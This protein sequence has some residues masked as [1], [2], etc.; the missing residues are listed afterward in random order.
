MPATLRLHC[1]KNG[2]DR[3]HHGQLELVDSEMPMCVLARNANCDRGPLSVAHSCK[4]MLPLE[5]L[6]AD[7]L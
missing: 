2:S 4:V 6:A 7:N 3:G 5:L 1:S